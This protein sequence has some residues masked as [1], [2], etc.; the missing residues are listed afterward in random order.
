MNTVSKN[1]ER[2]HT[3]VGIALF[4]A[5][6]FVLQFMSASIKLGTF[7]IASLALVTMV[8]GAALYGALA[9][10]WLGFVFGV[11]VLISGDAA[12][13]LA[14]DVFGTIATVLVK[15]AAA[16]LVAGLVYRLI[17]KHNQVIAAIAAAAAAP[18]V[19]TGI[20][21]L[22]CRL[23]FFNTIAAEGAGQGYSNTW[24]YILLF[25]VGFNFVV[26]FLINLAINPVIIRLV[27]IGKKTVK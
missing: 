8:V 7:S 25:Y 2:T 11:A 1:R 23:F 10:G 4:T 17:E 15:G 6:V 5:I 12:P 26:E 21:V 19:N 20:F 24:V 27:N 22:G 13:F 3:L 16:G 14:L 9:G 18:I